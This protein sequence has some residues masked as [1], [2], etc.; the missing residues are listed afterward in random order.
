MRGLA[1]RQGADRIQPER[2]WGVS[3]Q[4]AGNDGVT[5]WR[6]RATSGK[7]RRFSIVVRPGASGTATLELRGLH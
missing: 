2:R 3:G 5:P 4:H 1:S 7:A 6:R